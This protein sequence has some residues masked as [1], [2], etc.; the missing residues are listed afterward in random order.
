[1]P[2]LRR[3][4]LS[5]EATPSQKGADA[6]VLVGLALL[7]RPPVRVTE[8]RGDPRLMKDACSWIDP[9]YDQD[10]SVADQR[11]SMASSDSEA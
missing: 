11:R 3:P 2:E 7:D 6:C 8:K 10:A 9:L 1:M 5:G 4:G